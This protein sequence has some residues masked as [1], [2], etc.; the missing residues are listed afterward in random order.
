MQARYPTS[1]WRQWTSRLYLQVRPRP[2]ASSRCLRPSR[3][4]AGEEGRTAALAQGSMDS[5]QSNAA[6]EGGTPDLGAAHGRASQPPLAGL[7][8]LSF[9]LSPP[10]LFSSLCLLAAAAGALRRATRASSTTPTG[11][12]PN[13]AHTDRR[14]TG[15]GGHSPR[16]GPR[17]TTGQSN[18]RLSDQERFKRRRRTYCNVYTNKIHLI[19]SRTLCT[20]LR[21]CTHLTIVHAGRSASI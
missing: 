1:A 10:P 4:A 11:A 5:A 21:L 19:N 12:R 20:T 2:L 16:H 7:S 18:F 8:S 15:R 9:S 6:E 17:T 14:E 13:K 3:D